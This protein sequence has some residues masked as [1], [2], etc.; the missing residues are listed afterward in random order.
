M[1]REH[2]YT[3][4]SRGRHGNELFVVAEDRRVEERHSAE[5]DVDPLDAVRR[6]IGRSASKRMA[7]DDVEPEVAPLEQLRRD[8]ARHPR[9]PR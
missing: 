9:P 5:V 2:A 6:A 7:L 4:L 3:A 8:R 1:T